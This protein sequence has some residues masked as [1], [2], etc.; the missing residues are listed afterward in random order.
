MKKNRTPGNKE[1][2]ITKSRATGA[3]L[4]AFLIGGLC[5]FMVD[6]YAP[7]NDPVSSPGIEIRPGGYEFINPLLECD[8]SQ[9]AV[10]GKDLR[11]LKQKI[12]TAIENKKKEQGISH[13][14]VY[15]RDL[16]N[17]PWIGVEEKAP[18]SPSSLLK[19][20]L[21]IAILKDAET[22][23]RIL[24]QRLTYTDREDANAFE[25]INPSKAIM[26]GK[27]YTVEELIHF[28][29]VYSDNN[30][31][32][33]LL[34]NFP[35]TKLIKVYSELGVEVPYDSKK[36]DFMSVKEY[37]SFFRILFN[38]SYL[39]REMSMKA[40]KMLSVVD[41]KNGII[42]GVPATVGVAHKFGERSLG[43]AGEIK[44]LHDCG[45]VYYPN[46]PYL[47]CVMTR[48]LSFPSLNETIKDISK[49]FYNELDAQYRSVL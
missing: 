16:N 29:I 4:L 13:V 18:F 47:L 14:S 19:V 17:G 10:E 38:A 12:K 11:V 46:H 25:N 8:M 2:V 40:L 44:Q 48:G 3:L 49:L 32:L 43:V 26:R 41:Y 6:R 9:N 15:F 39:N 37:A 27:P 36:E 5:G 20:P 7:G 22:N 35:Q 21:M 34:K 33:L 31:Y 30:A 1:K 28:T 23:P 24:Q 45:I 42:A